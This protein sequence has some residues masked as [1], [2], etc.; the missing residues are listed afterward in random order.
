MTR[1]LRLL[2][3][4]LLGLGAG[5]A[6]TVAGAVPAHACSCGPT[7]DGTARSASDVVFVGRLV[8]RQEATPGPFGL[9]PPAVT[10]ILVFEVDRVFK[11]TATARQ[12]LSTPLSSGSCGW[13]PTSDRPWLVF[14][15]GSSDTLSTQL[16]IGNREG[17]AP[18]AWGTGAAPAAGEAGPQLPS[19]AGPLRS[20]GIAAGLVAAGT[21]AVLLLAR[22]LRRR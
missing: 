12:R 11:G 16:C 6:V 19:S 2:L 1:F 22:R 9:G 18:A 8:E 14:A 13:E 20:L 10:A 4:A 17:A 5:L 3:T 7:D 21:A 15:T